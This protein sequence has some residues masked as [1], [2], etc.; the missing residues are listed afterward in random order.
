MFITFPNHVST[1]VER[2]GGPTFAAHAAGVSNTTIHD[3]I[4]RNRIPNIKHA[5]LV[6]SLV[7]MDVQRLRPTK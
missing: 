1:A 5:K 3:W 4:R 2:L 6:A 7:G